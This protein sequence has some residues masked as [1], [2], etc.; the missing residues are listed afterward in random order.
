M[1]HMH[2]YSAEIH[3]KMCKTWK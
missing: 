1:L 3:I 2:R